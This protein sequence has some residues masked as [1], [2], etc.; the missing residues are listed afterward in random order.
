MGKEEQEG[1]KEMTSSK[2]QCEFF[3]GGHF[4]VREEMDTIGGLIAEDLQSVLEG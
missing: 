2:F 4:F 3:P 1:W